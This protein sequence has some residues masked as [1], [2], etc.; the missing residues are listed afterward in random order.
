MSQEQELTPK[1]TRRRRMSSVWIIPMVAL[2]LAGWLVWKNSVGKGPLVT[3]T[4]ET[5]EGLG[6]GKT[7]IRCRSVKVGMVE[8]VKLNSKLSGVVVL[9]RIEPDAVDLLRKDSRFWVV[10]PRITLQSVSGVD[11]LLSGAYIELEPGES[12]KVSRK[13]IYKGLE[14]PPV[15]SANVPGLRLVLN[16]E[17]AGSLTVGAPVYYRGYEVGRVERRRFD[18]EKEKV[19]FN[20]FIQEAF[21]PLV[22]KNTH[23]WNTSGIKIDAGANGFKLQTASLRAIVAGGV[24]FDILKGEG[25][26]SL[27]Q[28]G[29][30]YRLFP[31]R[32]LAEAATFD[33]DYKILLFFNQSVR[34]LKRGAPVEFRGL[35]FGRVSDISFKYSESGDSRVP[36]LVEV[37]TETLRNRFSS[38]KKRDDLLSELLSRG[39][40]AKLSTASLL[41]GALFV[42][43][44]FND[45]REPALLR[46]VNH[47]PV[48]PTVSSG[49]AQIETKI[50]DFLNKLTALPIAETMERFGKTADE[51]SLTLAR[52]RTTLEELDKTLKDTHDLLGSDETQQLSQKLN[53]ALVELRRTVESVGPNGSVQGDLRRTLDELRSAI[54]SFESLS[55]TI[56]EKPNSLLFGRDS[57]GDPIPR[58]RKK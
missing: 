55:R 21:A 42:E 44:E 4:F 6:E 7:E 26:S 2:L 22:C 15:T 11:T 52:T 39:L 45:S 23:F 51:A 35:P 13:K 27:A 1:I 30:E 34:G 46:H 25:R 24:S 9:A 20:I 19:L 32:S 48:V 3:I 37:D 50:D 49:F 28:N 8:S 43:F 33:P 54:R 56:D 16:S 29:D 58:A 40:N 53:E 12:Q 17:E 14:E 38:D 57:S 18:V 5:A 36:V 47:Y 41:T 10:R 31:D